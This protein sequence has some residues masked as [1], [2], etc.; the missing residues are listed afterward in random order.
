MKIQKNDPLKRGFDKQPGGMFLKFLNA[1]FPLTQEQ[2]KY[3]ASMGQT[4]QS[5]GL[6]DELDEPQSPTSRGAE[7][8]GAESMGLRSE[9]TSFSSRCATGETG[10]VVIS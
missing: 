5:L 4:S 3:H 6:N 8:R 1:N 2:S 10:K 7:S 9:A